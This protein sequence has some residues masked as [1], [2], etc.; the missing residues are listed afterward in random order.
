[1]DDWERVAQL[2]PGVTGSNCMFKWLSI[3]KTNLSNCSWSGEESDL[4]RGIIEEQQ[5]IRS[6]E[7]FTHLNWK[8]VAEE[9]YHSNASPSKVFRSSKQCREHW[10]C[11]LNPRLKKGPWLASEDMQLLTLIKNNNGCKKWSEI[12][13]Y[14]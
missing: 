3:R 1:M 7:E 11:F 14:F 5:G 12:V 9:L 10:N 8:T 6:V 2:I 4:L 13:Y